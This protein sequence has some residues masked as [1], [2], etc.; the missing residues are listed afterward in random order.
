MP[1][2]RRPAGLRHPGKSRDRL[3]GRRR[4][5]R[6]SRRPVGRSSIMAQVG[7]LQALAD[8]GQ[9]APVDEFGPS[10]ERRAAP[11][12]RRR[13]VGIAA[14]TLADHRRSAEHLSRDAARGA[15]T[16]PPP[17]ERMAPSGSSAA[18][19]RRSRRSSASAGDG[20]SDRSAETCVTGLRIIR[21][22]RKHRPRKRDR[23]RR[24]CRARRRRRGRPI[25]I[26]RCRRR[27]DGVVDC[28]TLSTSRRTVRRD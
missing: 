16:A 18:R 23:G 28:A 9:H 11:S 25:A 4:T 21:R 17:G 14:T 12:R 1:R 27:E 15:S 19:P 6:R 26:D 2:S 7:K 22:R 24:S 8:L 3:P 13:R 10:A 20:G 5:R